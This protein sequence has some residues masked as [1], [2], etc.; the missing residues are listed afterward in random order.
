MSTP[1]TEPNTGRTERFAQLQADV[2]AFNDEMH[3]LSARPADPHKAWLPFGLG[4]AAA[5][6]AFAGAALIQ[7]LI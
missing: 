2:S 3:K 1:R 7:H 6:V 4:A 5:L